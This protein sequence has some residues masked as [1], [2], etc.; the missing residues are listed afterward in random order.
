MLGTTG[1]YYNTPKSVCIQ[2]VIDC[3]PTVDNHIRV[4]RKNVMTTNTYGYIN[5]LSKGNAGVRKKIKHT[6][7]GFVHPLMHFPFIDSMASAAS[8]ALQY[9]M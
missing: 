1:L 9:V 3:S 4:A 7:I 8:D 2:N 5:C 6:F